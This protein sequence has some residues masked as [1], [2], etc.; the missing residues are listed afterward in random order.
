VRGLL[1]PAESCFELR[2]SGLVLLHLRT[3]WP[4]RS[5]HAR[6]DSAR[7]QRMFQ[8]RSIAARLLG[9]GRLWKGP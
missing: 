4:G 8:G 1:L 9:Q 6:D 2:F 3:L 7:L 5:K